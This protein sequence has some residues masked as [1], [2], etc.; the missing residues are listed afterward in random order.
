MQ[1][2]AFKGQDLRGRSF[3]N[4][5]LTGADFSDCDLRGVDFS[6]ANLTDAKFCNVQMGKTIKASETASPK[7]LVPCRHKISP[8]KTQYTSKTITGIAI[9]TAAYTCVV[10]P[11]EFSAA[12][13]A[14]ESAK[15]LHVSPAQGINIWE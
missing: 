8:P 6:F 5:D 12:T 7:R 14:A 13:S 11:Q 3:K 4:Q 15:K 2:K 9:I 1:T 10:S